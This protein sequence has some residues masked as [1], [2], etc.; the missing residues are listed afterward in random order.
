MR[1]NNINLLTLHK[2]PVKII[3]QHEI[4]KML[5]S[6]FFFFILSKCIIILVSFTYITLI[7]MQITNLV[8]DTE[9]LTQKYTQNL[10]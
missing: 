6:Y 4:L 8:E 5:K 10:I 3:P 9:T 2:V 1:A 7:A